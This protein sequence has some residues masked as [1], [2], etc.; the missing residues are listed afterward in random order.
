MD[1]EFA[2]GG[3]SDFSAVKRGSTATAVNA[4]FVTGNEADFVGTFVDFNSG[5]EIDELF[6]GL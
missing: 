2:A 6:K 4:E 1:G 5:R 3:V